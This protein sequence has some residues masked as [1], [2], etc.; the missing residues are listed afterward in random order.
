MN[1]IP[2][3]KKFISEAEKAASNPLMSDVE[4]EPKKA[5]PTPAPATPAPAT[6]APAAPAE[7]AP[8]SHDET[9]AKADEMGLK[10]SDD[11]TQ[12]VPKEPT[13][14]GDTHTFVNARDIWQQAGKPQDVATIRQILIDG[15]LSEEIIDKAFKSVGVGTMRDKLKS[16]WGRLKGAVSGAVQGW[17]QGAQP[18]PS[19]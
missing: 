4:D 14:A 17:Q 18:T 11:G 3:F 6:P 2:T 9:L 16:G 12:W 1:N 5:E 8:M 19:A 10:L 7:D 15:G 13:P